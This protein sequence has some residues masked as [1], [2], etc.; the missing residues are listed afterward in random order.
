MW[1]KISIIA[2]LIVL[3]LFLG[4][5]II[6]AINGKQQIKEAIAILPSFEF[7]TLQNRPYTKDSLLQNQSTLFLFFNTTC[8][9]CQYETG[10]ILKNAN[11]LVNKNVLFI[12]WIPSGPV[13][14]VTKS[15]FTASDERRGS[16][17]AAILQ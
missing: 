16:V 3:A 17:P 7:Y 9:H 13:R 10:Q 2:L 15:P 6:S 14:N 11:Q 12:S 5:K 4:Y 1:R 8:E